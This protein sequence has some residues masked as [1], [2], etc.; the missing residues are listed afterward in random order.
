MADEKKKILIVED[1]RNIS[2]VLRINLELAGYY[3]D[4]A[5][6]GE[7]GLQ[8]A[9]NGN[10]D[11]ILLDIMLPKRDGFSVCREVRKTLSTPIIMVTAKEEE[12]D[13]VLGLDLGADDYVTKPCSIKLLLSRIRANIRRFSGEYAETRTQPAVPCEG[14][15]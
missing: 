15:T 10:Y 11:L 9:L 7:E 1:E 14:R 13:K 2:Q 8:K 5:F 6:D 3:C 12:L 4:D